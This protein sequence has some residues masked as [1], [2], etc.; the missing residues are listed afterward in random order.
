[1]KKVYQ[2]LP[3][4]ILPLTFLLMAFSPD[5]PDGK[6]ET[7]VRSTSVL[8]TQYYEG[9]SNDKWIE[10]TNVGDVTVDLST[11]YIG[12]WSNTNTPSGPAANFSQ[13]SGTIDAGQV[14]LFKHASAVLP[15]YA[16]GTGTTGCYF[17]GND[18]VAIMDG[19]N[20]WSDRVDCIYG[21]DYWGGETSFYRNADVLTGNL[22]MSDFSVAG[23][24]TEVTVVAVNNALPAT[25]ERLGY[26]VYDGGS[27]TVSTPVFDPPAG[28]YNTPIEVAITC[29]TPDA[30]IVYTTDGTDP[31][32]SSEEY[33]EP[34]PISSTTTLK[35]RAY[36][37][38]YTP[39]SIATGE[40]IYPETIS[41][42]AEFRAGTLGNLYFISGEVVLTYQEAWNNQKYIQDA[43]AAILIYDYNGIITSDYE[44]G[45]GITGLLGTLATYG[46]MLE[47][48]PM[49]DPG[50][51]T[52]SGNV[53]VPEVIT[54]AEMNANFENYEAELVKIESA[55][56]T[57]GGQSFLEGVVY[58]ITDDS[59][60]TGNF[61]TTFYD[62]DYLYTT[63]PVVPTDIIGICNSRFDGDY[64][65]SRFST[66]L[67]PNVTVPTIVVISP[68]GF[69]FWQ[70]GSTHNIT[71]A[72]IDFTDDV[73]INL[74]RLPFFNQTLATDVPN[75]GSWE[76]TI[77]ED[78]TPA[79]N[80]KIYI[81]GLDPE[82]PSDYS[83][84]NF[85]IIETLPVP[86]IVINEIMYNPPSSLG[87][88]A[89]FE[90]LE[91]YNN[92]GFDVNLTNWYLS[93]AIT[94]TFTSGT[95]LADGQYLVVALKPDSIIAHY[96]IT[97]VVGPYS[98]ALNNT[99]ES[100]V[101]NAS[102]GTQMDIVS[103]Q[104]GG[105]W[106]PEANGQGPSLE[107]L[108]AN[109]DN[110]L[111]ES[112]A[113]S[114]IN[115]GTPGAVNSV[116]GAEILTLLSPN[117]G[118]TFEQG[119]SQEIS[120]E[121]VGFEG[122]LK[123]ELITTTRNREILAENVPVADGLWD[124]EIP[125]DQTIGDNF[126]IKIS[127]MDDGEPMDESDGVF[128][129]VE[130]IIPSITLTS[131]NGGESWA[132]GTSHDITWTYAFFTGDV[133][134]EL[135]DGAKALTL[136]EDSIPVGSGSY[137]WSIPVDQTT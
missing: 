119:S 118:E 97:N 37:E 113:A 46:N 20:D 65:T 8:I 29:A 66:D 3:L 56:F 23:E 77:P 123:I 59:D 57:N 24:W 73:Q 136:I 36:F 60:A 122:F 10:V 31:D 51:P 6:S 30:I 83:D 39:S 110:N 41:T 67:I 108:D 84:D 34:I 5:S 135:S 28:G 100:I 89:D 44:I 91:L 18:P 121:Y 26:H 116:V 103:Y 106:P 96:G 54:I 80:Y 22:D 87:N 126:K 133:K 88:D 16:S 52:S 9:T 64:I 74:L 109:L 7:S 111:P 63:I 90:Y 35:A 95:I 94:Y 115:N 76:W 14:I 43:T 72:S 21:T 125:G 93:T 86:D 25:T 2:F 38:D 101:L 104:N 107:L 75:T 69:E 61:R 58:E 17:N 27:L 45:D 81:S 40:Y 85:S 131:P 55:S 79:D 82:D 62:A 47:F 105:L 19:S 124:W 13:M 12:R 112:W 71:W 120:W 78:L 130:L 48:I 92:S 102:D 99:G 132:Q 53:I 117:G 33:D 70:L 114:L 98:G 11:Y 4:L 15:S 137:P 1:M 127:D 42:L 32:L 129:I 128:S 134:I 50:D 68:N 49:E